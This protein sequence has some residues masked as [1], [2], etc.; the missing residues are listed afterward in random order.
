MR[1]RTFNQFLFLISLLFSMTMFSCS[2]STDGDKAIISGKLEGVNNS[3]FVCVSD[4]SR[5]SLLIDTVQI[6]K[7][8]EFKHTIQTNNII[9]VSLFFQEGI[10]VSPIF[11]EKGREVKIAGNVFNPLDLKIEGGDDN[12]NLTAF[13]AENKK[14]IENKSSALIDSAQSFVDRNKAN[15]ASLAIIDTYL[16]NALEGY[17]LDSLYSSLSPNIKDILYANNIKISIEAKKKGVKGAY[18]SHFNLKNT[19]GET[20]KLTD[21]FHKKLLLVFTEKEDSILSNQLDSIHL[22]MKDLEIIPFLIT[23]N[24]PESKKHTLFYDQKSWASAFVANYGVRSVPYY[25]MIGK[26]QKIAGRGEFG[27]GTMKELK[28]LD[29]N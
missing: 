4:I 29:Q 24:K 21:F 10:S 9:R 28:D 18:A 2:S 26:D 27:F 15:I 14:L 19:K 22:N 17:E 11:V 1:N 7:E 20:K 25:V 13:R 6:S 3:F 16:L 23:L 5:D 8:G 12:N